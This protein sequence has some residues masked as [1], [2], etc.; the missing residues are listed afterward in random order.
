MGKILDLTGQQFG[1]LTVI[2]FDES[3][4]HSKEKR[5][6]CRCYCGNMKS[7]QTS[8]LRSGHAMSCGCL[9]KESCLS[10]LPKEFRKKKHGMSDTKLFHVYEGMIQ[11]CENPKKP[12]FKDYG[13][14]GIKV[15]TEW[16]SNSNNFL[17]WALTHGYHEGLS[18]D[19][20]DPN[21]NYCPENCRWVSN[22][23]QMRNRRNTWKITIDGIEK[24]T[25]EWCEI[26][27]INYSTF[28][29][30]I[31]RGMNEKQALTAPLHEGGSDKFDGVAASA[32]G[33]QMEPA[34]VYT[35]KMA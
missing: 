2:K 1:R 25:K 30:R 16:R 28:Q 21:G 9:K 32:N 20:I 18:I 22:K 27:K 13:G 12:F 35:S 17:C 5:W 3:S 34:S 6:I 4:V 29:S 8:N 33:N 26:F 10:N 11:R 14:R 31:R 24:S 15:C 23:V 7:V 19:R